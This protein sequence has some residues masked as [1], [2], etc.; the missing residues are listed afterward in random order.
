MEAPT[1]MSGILFMK[2]HRL[3]RARIQ[4]VLAQYDLNPTY[5]SILGAAIEAKEGIRLATVA[6]ML[7][8]KAPMITMMVDDLSERGLMKRIPHHTDKRA[9]LLVAT[10]KG[11]RLIRGID[12]ELGSEVQ[13]LV[14]G[15]TADEMIIFRKVLQT[16]ITNAG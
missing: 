1:Y 12:I 15:L 13:S 5:W 9:K 16:I 8:V 2:A 7:G 14:A 6:T 4:A 10:P 3:V 11:K